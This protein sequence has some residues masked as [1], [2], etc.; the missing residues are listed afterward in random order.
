[1]MNKCKVSFITVMITVIFSLINV[2][3]A[4]ADD[5][6]YTNMNGVVLTE[7]EYH[8]LSRVF[9]EDTIA[10]MD[11][12]MINSLKDNYSLSIID[13]TVKYVRVDS[14]VDSCGNVIKS[15]E[16]EVSKEQ[17]ENFEQPIYP[18]S[19]DITYQTSI[20]KLHM[21]IIGGDSSRK[22]IT[23]TNTWLSIPST[24]SYDVIAIRIGSA[25]MELHYNDP[26][27]GYQ[28]YDG[29]VI[30]YN[31]SSSNLKKAS[32]GIGLS[33]NIKDNVSSSLEN[34][35]TVQ[36][37]KGQGNL[38]IFGTY[39][40]AQSP[41]TLSESKS[42]SFGDGLG[43]VLVFSNSSIGNKYDGMKGVSLDYTQF[44]EIEG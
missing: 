44:E 9:N 10:T 8:N 19:H 40:H 21:T 11:S 33:M 27:S 42:Y 28:K 35:L 29:Q 17:A 31:S 3:P 16:K 18:Q 38:K 2:I 34:S 14:V 13:D 37:L 5:A 32:K 22:I 1:M 41:V 24:K 39:Q 20:K 36:L 15:S 30:S 25:A 23:L 43:S 6:Y 4:Y 12:D 7:S 26:I